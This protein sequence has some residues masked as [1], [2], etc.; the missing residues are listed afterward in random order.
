MSVKCQLPLQYL[1]WRAIEL[2]AVLVVAGPCW[3]FHAENQDLYSAIDDRYGRFL[4]FI[5]HG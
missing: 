3:R 5:R 2:M 1:E 4:G